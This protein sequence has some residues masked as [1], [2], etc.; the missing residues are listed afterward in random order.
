[1]TRRL[2]K[3][4]AD[5]VAIAISPVLIMFLVGSLLFFLVEVFYVGRYD[6][7]M[8]WIFFWFTVAI[9]L[10]ARISIELGQEKAGIYAALLAM[11]VFLAMSQFVGGS[12]LVT[13]ALIG[14]IWWSSHKLTLD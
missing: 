9:V 3:T 2:D 1:M 7:R 13:M 14:L 4:L 6:A 10:I 8:N 12:V 11:A 5:Y